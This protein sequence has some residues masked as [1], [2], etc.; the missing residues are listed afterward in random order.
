MPV[1]PQGPAEQL[2]GR[3]A[4]TALQRAAPGRA[5]DL[6][7]RVPARHP[8][9]AAL[10]QTPTPTPPSPPPSKVGFPGNSPAFAD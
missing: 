9:L 5:R 8:L 1:L 6:R 3:L 2:L 4:A 7:A 10:G